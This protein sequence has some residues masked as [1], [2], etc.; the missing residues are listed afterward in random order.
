MKLGK[1][2]QGF[3]LRAISLLPLLGCLKTTGI[4]AI[5]ATQMQ[6]TLNTS[7]KNL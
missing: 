6:K 3:V 2:M 1:Q 4:F 5:V 7:L